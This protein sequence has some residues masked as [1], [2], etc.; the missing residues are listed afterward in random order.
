LE[1]LFI[2]YK[3][4]VINITMKIILYSEGRRAWDKM[5]HCKIALQR[6][7]IQSSN[8]AHL[9]RNFRDANPTA[10]FAQEAGWARG[11]YRK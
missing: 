3:S 2:H 1:H 10:N 5:P 7:P 9:D 8:P 4:E 11:R 6:R